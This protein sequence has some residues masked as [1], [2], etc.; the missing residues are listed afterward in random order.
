MRFSAALFAFIWAISSTYEVRAD[1]TVGYDKDQYDAVIEQINELEDNAER[2]RRYIEYKEQLH[3]EYL[4]RIADLY[5]VSTGEQYIEV[6]QEEAANIIENGIDGIKDYLSTGGKDKLGALDAIRKQ[7]DSLEK[8]RD[9]EHEFIMSEDELDKAIEGEE[10]LRRQL[11]RASQRLRDIETNQ[12]PE[13]EA[14][15]STDWGQIWRDLQTAIGNAAAVAAQ[16]QAYQ[17]TRRSEYVDLRRVPWTITTTDENGN[18]TTT[19]GEYCFAKLRSYCPGASPYRWCECAV[20]ISQE[21]EVSC[22]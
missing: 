5:T 17:N 20:T 10:V 6:S 13:L 14:K 16:C 3:R 4:Q 19:T 22:P 7:I 1:V 11:E 8:I 15:V 21:F 12:I 9:A 2:L 18:T